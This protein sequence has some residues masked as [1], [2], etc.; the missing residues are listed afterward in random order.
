MILVTG[1]T[2]HVGAEVAA[3]LARRGQPVRA[4]VRDPGQVQLPGGVQAVPGDLGR[5]DTLEQ[6]AQGASAA[7]LLPGFPGSAAA[8]RAAGVD[9]IVLLSGGSAG[10]GDM[11]NAVTR[12]M[13]ESEQEV[14]QSGAS[15]TF[16]RP[17]AFMA[18]AL[19][20]L[21]KLRAGDTL[22]LPFA[23]VRTACIDPYDIGAVAAEFLRED[24]DQH[25]GQIYRLSGPAAML[26]EEQVATLAEVLGRPLR[27]EAQPDDEARQE[28]L[29]DTP[30]DLVDAFFDFYVAGTLDESP[31]LPTVAK[32]TGRE[33]RAFRQWA[34]AHAAEFR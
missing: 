11:S 33:P 13:A 20:W 2:G 9:R 16:L 22:R 10:S 14:R 18:N 15:W 27:F 17:A 24:Q 7:F 6:A 34:S 12:Y 25:T 26:P 28:M 32:I 4:M 29:K 19:R 21:P 8:L 30:P 1:A 23:S 5:P 3:E 31:V